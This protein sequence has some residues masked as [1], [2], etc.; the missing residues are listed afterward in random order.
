MQP[1]S[2]AVSRGNE[3][4]NMNNPKDS[5]VRVGRGFEWGI[6]SRNVRTYVHVCYAQECQL[7]LMCT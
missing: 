5:S 6:Y 7:A 3:S 2:P 1:L 4:S